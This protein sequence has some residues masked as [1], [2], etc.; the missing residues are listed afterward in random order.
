MKHRYEAGDDDEL[1]FSPGDTIRV[2]EL[3]DD[4]WFGY[5]ETA[6]TEAEAAAVGAS[7]TTLWGCKASAI[8]HAVEGEAPSGARWSVASSD[9]LARSFDAVVLATHAAPP[10]PA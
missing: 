9:G 2:T 4:W 5:V 10:H 6:A 7:L 1:S 8:T 3:D